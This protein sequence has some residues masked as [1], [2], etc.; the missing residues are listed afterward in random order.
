LG[1]SIAG[2]VM[3]SSAV[4]LIILMS[5]LTESFSWTED[6]Y[7]AARER[8]VPV[9]I[10]APEQIKV[11]QIKVRQ[12][13]VEQIEAEQT[14][15]KQIEV[16]QIEVMRSPVPVVLLS[17]GLGGSRDGFGYLGQALSK[18]G[19][20][21]IVMQ[22]TGS[23]IN[24]RFTR[25]SGETSLQAM[26][27]AA[28]AD[29]AQQR[30][31]D[32]KFVLAELE[33]RD[34]EKR[35]KEENKTEKHSLVC[36][37]DFDKIGIG[38]H[39]FGSQTAFAAAG[40]LPYRHIGKIKAAVAMSP[41]VPKNVG[42]AFIHKS[43]TIPMLH[44]TGTDDRSPLDKSFDPKDRRLPFDNI[45][46]IDQYLV[47]FTGGTHLLFS[48]H[49]RPLGMTA[50]ENKCQPVIAEIITLF[51]D[52]YLKENE[53]AKRKIQGGKLDELMKSLGTVEKKLQR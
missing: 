2:I 13:E 27:R 33:K 52:A 6:W 32:I 35:D 14:E 46:G 49:R 39:S 22:H 10:F 3:M 43:I 1:T 51:F 37:I 45:I 41:N 36:K 4:F 9:R 29:E 42:A 12:T 50:M 48:G 44:L 15:V 28:N 21:V 20:F 16:E 8:S 40:R 23:D 5:L 24:L 34:L 19:Y 31:D 30:Y 26:S 38:G 11:E 17:H 25:K 47:I 53:A 7:D 18:S